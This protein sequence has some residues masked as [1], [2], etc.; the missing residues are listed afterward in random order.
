MTGR[1]L[2]IVCRDVITSSAASPLRASASAYAYRLDIYEFGPF[3]VD[4]SER[5]LL[6][7]E[8]VVPL[9][10]KAFEMLLV[11]VQS[12]GHVFTK[13]ELMKR[14]W[15]DSFVEEANLSHNVYKLREAL[16]DG[17]NGERYIE[18]MPRRGYRFVAKVTGVSDGGVDLIVEEHSRARILIEEDNSANAASPIEIIH[19][20]R[21]SKLLQGAHTRRLRLPRPVLLVA[22]TVVLTAIVATLL[23]LRTTRPADSAHGPARL[24]SIAVL[25]F[26]PLATND[27][28]E[29]LEMGMADTLISRLGIIEHLTVRPF[30]A[31]RKYNKLDDEVV[32]AGRDLKVDAVLDGSIQKSG[33]RL[34]VSVRLIQVEQGAVVWTEQFDEKFTDI[35]AVQD[36][37]AR[38]V[39]DQLALKLSAERIGTTKPGT[40][41]ADAYLAYLKGR[42][43]FR[44]FNPADHQ[45]AE[46]YFNEAITIDPHYALAYAGLSDTYGASAVNNWLPSTEAYPK[47]KTFAKK[48]L[49]IDSTLAEAHCTSGAISMFYD[50]DWVTA[51]REYK[52]ALKLNPNHLETYEVYSYFLSC[53][54]RLDEGIEMAQ[55]G[56]RVD[57]LSVALSDDAAGAYYW[58]RRYDEAIRQGQK[59][60]E[61]DPNHIGAS[62]SSAKLMY[63]REGTMKPS[64]LIRRRLTFRNEPRTS[65]DFWVI[66][67]RSVGREAMP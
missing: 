15:P 5:L 40:E 6:R 16:G 46:Q 64:R 63:S 48:A 56:L 55:R 1:S 21:G 47:A 11:L 61:L 44:K 22:I 24:R 58:A 29:S 32:Q 10:P 31:V 52:E 7:G 4:E 66:C 9:T 57:P 12:S 14:V 49:E 35:F 62:V 34:R 37:I 59:S 25:P 2:E 30:S 54:G 60:I 53:I 27:R 17:R 36:S 33:D 13:E 39:G 18:T 20:E 8:D 38:R 51:E 45:R 19:S 41:N 28:D 43:F 26:K 3:R 67:L 65:W 23:Y 42:Y 50:L